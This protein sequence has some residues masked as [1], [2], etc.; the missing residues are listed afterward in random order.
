MIT[1]GALGATVSINVDGTYLSMYYSEYSVIVQSFAVGTAIHLITK[2]TIQ[3]RDQRHK[4][5][6]LIKTL[7]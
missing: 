7:H 6:H 4:Y 3:N 2:L 1:V 5:H